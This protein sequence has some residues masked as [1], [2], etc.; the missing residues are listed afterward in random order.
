MEIEKKDGIVA[1]Q[2][3]TYKFTQMC[4]ADINTNTE[5]NI[6]ALLFLLCVVVCCVSKYVK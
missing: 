1:F 4:L 2:Y 5:N 6:Y 3:I